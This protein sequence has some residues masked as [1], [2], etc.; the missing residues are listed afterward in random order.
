VSEPVVQTLADEWD[1]ITTLAGSLTDDDWATPTALPGW[2]VQD[3]L[4]HIIGIERMLLGDPAPEVSVS[5]LSHLSDPFSEGMETW[6]ELRRSW[7]PADVVADFRETIERRLAALRAMTDDDFAKVGWSPVGEVPYRQFMRIRVFDC[8]MHEQ[9][10]RRA[11]G[12]PGHLEGPVVDMALENFE[13]TLGFIVGKKSGAPDGSSIVFV[14]E[15]PS[16]RT[17]PVV[18]EGRAKLLPAAE[19]PE[20][21][22][23]TITLPLESFVALGGGRWDREEAW[24]AGSLAI[25]GDVE[26]G[27]AV[28]DNFAFTP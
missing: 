5:H 16:A 15:G 2:T 26:L 24:S 18:V 17:Y 20:D 21:P 19:A 27:T 12:R 8:W 25:D 13:R 7:P 3:N 11:I 22:T 1:A 6:V 10:I 14:I 9:D 28:L 4:S 23:V